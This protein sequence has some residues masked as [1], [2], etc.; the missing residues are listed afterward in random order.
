M[1]IFKWLFRL[2]LI[3]V[4]IFGV[5]YVSNYKWEGKPI[6]EHVKEAYESGLISEGIKDFKTWITELFN[7]NQKKIGDRLT[8]KDMEEI[9]RIIKNELKDN[10]KKLK[11]ESAEKKK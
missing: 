4:A 1:F 5:I 8:N 3:A 6:K 11:E 10:V 9:E 7:S 2:V